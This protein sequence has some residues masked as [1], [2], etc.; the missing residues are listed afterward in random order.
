MTVNETEALLIKLEP[1]GYRSFS[2]LEENVQTQPQ[3]RMSKNDLKDGNLPL[4]GYI[5]TYISILIK[6]KDLLTKIPSSGPSNNVLLHRN[7]TQTM[8]SQ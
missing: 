3:P 7:L 5:H 1:Q 8:E 4:V 2:T 6:T